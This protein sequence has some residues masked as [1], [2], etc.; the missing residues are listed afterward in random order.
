MQHRSGTGRSGFTKQISCPTAG[1]VSERCRRKDTV[2]RLSLVCLLALT[3]RVP[4]ANAQGFSAANIPDGAMQKLGDLA[5]AGQS[6]N[7]IAFTTDGGGVGWAILYGGGYWWGGIPA[8]AAQKLG[9]V[10]NAGLKSIAFTPNGGWAILYGT[11]GFAWSGIP[12]AAAQ[13]LG[14][15]AN[16]GQSLKSIAFTTDGGWAI[17]Y[18]NSG[19]ASSGIPAGAVL[20]LGDLA[21]AGQGLKSIAFAPGGGWAILQEGGGGT[22]PTPTTPTD[23]DLKKLED[24]V[25]V[26]VNQ[27]RAAAGLA[28]YIRSPELD[29]AARRHSLDQAA[30]CSG[31]THTGSDG[32]GPGE[33]I[34]AAGY[35][36]TSWGENTAAGQWLPIFDEE[37]R[38]VMDVWMNEQPD[39]L[40]NRPHR[41]NIL[42]RTAKEIGIAVAFNENC[43]VNGCSTCGRYYWTQDFGAR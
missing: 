12:D 25:F 37:S 24:Q 18:G 4:I 29:A 32:S 14:D 23:A 16:A 30:H 27:A 43:V 21:N 35:N 39:A 3:M 22:T 11:N 7:S 8:G 9:E 41:D 1:V 28:P 10:A 38:N 2:Y 19:F 31:P 34:E 40:G 5:N 26:L 20:K 42:S 13:K 15:L 6:L 17:L 36:W 33:R